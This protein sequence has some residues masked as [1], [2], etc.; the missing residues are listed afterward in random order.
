MLVMG[1]WSHGAWAG[2][3]G[4]RL[5]DARF[6]TDTGDYYRQN[7]ELIF[8]NSY[9]KE[10]GTMDLPEALVFETGSNRWRKFPAWPP[11]EA[12]EKTLYL[13]PGGKLG[14]QPPPSGAAYDEYVS[15]PAKPVP[16]TARITVSMP[17]DYMTEDQRFSANRP[18]VLVYQ[19][20][21][22]AQDITIAGPISP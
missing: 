13:L 20:D 18:D 7:V 8:F 15:D 22:L 9:L 12:T 16:S 4:D 2:V 3:P 17:G 6:S 1:P 21:P 5:G 14:F 11:K 19:T 10:K